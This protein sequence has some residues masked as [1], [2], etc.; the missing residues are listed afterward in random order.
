MSLPTV[1]DIYEAVDALA[2]FST[3]LPYDNAGLLVGS[4]SEPVRGIAFVLDITPAA[5]EWTAKQ[6]WNLIVS[7]HPILFHPA[8]R[9]PAD[10]AIYRMA[11][12]GM[13]AICAHTNLDCAPGGVNDVLAELLGLAS[14]E[15]LAD[16]EFPHHPPI[17]RIGCLRQTTDACGLAGLVRSALEVDAVGYADGGRPIT[18]VAVCGGAGAD[19]I[20]PAIQAGAQALVTADVRHHEL[21][22]AM[23]GGLTVVDGG[24]FATENKVL[25]PWM[26]RLKKCFPETPMQTIPQPSPLQFALKQ[27]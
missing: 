22:D 19:L 12:V 21:L 25:R 5:V 9:V 14:V 7:H 13:S 26:E 4:E 10:G 20:L 23:Q 3:A 27:R 16:P 1:Q 2:P 24:H 8:R 6:G 18:R 15:P 17:A 11:Q